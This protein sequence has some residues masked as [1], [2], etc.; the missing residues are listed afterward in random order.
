MQC[1]RKKGHK[2]KLAHHLP[3]LNLRNKASDAISG[4]GYRLRIK[5]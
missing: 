2:V 1:P 4:M 5:L 3:I